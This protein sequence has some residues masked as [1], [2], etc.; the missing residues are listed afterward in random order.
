MKIE[1]FEELESWKLARELTKVIYSVTKKEKF[2]KD[3][4]LRDQTQRAA[5]S[6][7][8]NPMKYEY[9]FCLCPEKKKDNK[10]YTG[11]T[12]NLKKRV[13]EHNEGQVVS[14]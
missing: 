13:A 2:S 11:Y 10:N 14:T 12:S 8:A 1:R 4:G 9:V 7:M 3:F 6:I 5:V